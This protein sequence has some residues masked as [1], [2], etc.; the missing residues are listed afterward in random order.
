VWFC[1]VAQRCGSVW[2]KVE[3]N[4]T[5]LA[6]TAIELHPFLGVACLP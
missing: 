2:S 3:V 1:L 4:A 6:P 5:G